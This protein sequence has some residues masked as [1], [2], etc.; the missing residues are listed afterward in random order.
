MWC[1]LHPGVGLP[2]FI[3]FVFFLISFLGKCFE[4]LL[5][6]QSYCQRMISRPISSLHVNINVVQYR[7]KKKYINV[8]LFLFSF[9]FGK[10]AMMFMWCIVFQLVAIIKKKVNELEKISLACSFFLFFGGGSDLTPLPVYS[11]CEISK[12]NP[13]NVFLPSQIVEF[14]IV[15]PQKKAIAASPPPSSSSL[16]LATPHPQLLWESAGFVRLSTL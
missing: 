1:R 11:L 13:K 8:V 16:H 3:L 6:V 5:I 15:R 4:S 2:Y 12:S 10:I 9:F 14:N 7:G